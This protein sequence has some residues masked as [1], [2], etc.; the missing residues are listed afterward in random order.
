M[1][2]LPRTDTYVQ[3]NAIMRMIRKC[4]I[5]RWVIGLETGRSGYDH[6]QIRIETRWTF[7]GMKQIFGEK[8]HIEEASDNWTYET[9]EGIYFSYRDTKANR[10]YR[11]GKLSRFQEWVLDCARTQDDR[12]IDVWYDPSGCHG[13]TWLAKHIMETGKG[14]V[15]PRNRMDDAHQCADFIIR[16]WRGGMEFIVF[17]IPRTYNMK[18]VGIY[19]LM[20]EVKDGLLFSTKYEGAWINIQPKVIIFTNNKL[21]TNKLSY[22]RWRFHGITPPEDPPNSGPS[23]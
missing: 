1:V 18:R 11:F 23:S 10:Q 4:D 13:K 12:Q 19:E 16:Q 6:F 9:K 7:E 22:D 15:V 14:V 5:K 3:F 2:T 8:A 17:D 20:E 21:D